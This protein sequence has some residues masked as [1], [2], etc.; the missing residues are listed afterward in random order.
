MYWKIYN[1]LYI[2]SQV[3]TDF[4]LRSYLRDCDQDALIPAYP[5]LEDDEYNTYRR[6]E[7]ELF[8]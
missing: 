5:L 1:N 2:G 7:M 3:G 4:V 8:I 6:V